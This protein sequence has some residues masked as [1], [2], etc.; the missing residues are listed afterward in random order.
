MLCLTSR[1]T[2]PTQTIAEPLPDGSRPQGQPLSQG[3]SAQPQSLG[4]KQQVAIPAPPA[5]GPGD[6]RAEMPLPQDLEIVDAEDEALAD[7]VEDDIDEEDAEVW[8][9]HA[10]PHSSK[11]FRGTRNL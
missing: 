5:M 2:S 4:L 9:L 8:G 1:S 3:S 10:A 6:M 7:T 11:L